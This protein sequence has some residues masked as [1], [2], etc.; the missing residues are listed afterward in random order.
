[1]VS[2]LSSGLRLGLAQMLASSSAPGLI[3][4][5]GAGKKTL[6]LTYWVSPIRHIAAGLPPRLIIVVDDDNQ[7]PR[8]ETVAVLEAMERSGR[9]LP[10][11]GRS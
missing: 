3:G 8:P 5:G 1:M 2:G 7:D 10:P 4:T 9:G 11:T 6:L